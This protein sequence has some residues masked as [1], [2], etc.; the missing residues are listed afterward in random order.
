MNN[1]TREYIQNAVDNITL[2]MFSDF[3]DLSEYEFIRLTEISN[4]LADVLTPPRYVISLEGWWWDEST[5]DRRYRLVTDLKSYPC[6]SAA[7][8][9]CDE[10]VDDHK[11]LVM[12]PMNLSSEFDG[13]AVCVYERRGSSSRIV[14]M[15]IVAPCRTNE[16]YWGDEAEHTAI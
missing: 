6:E 16:H 14:Q 11:N 10:L 1:R 5:D 7:V 4:E 8:D 9:E 12:A 3:S 15:H 13:M 2:S